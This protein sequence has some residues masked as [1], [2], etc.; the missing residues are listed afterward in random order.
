MRNLLEIEERILRNNAVKAGL[1][2][3]AINRV[4]RA[5]TNAK[6]QKFDKTLEMAKLVKGA[7]DWFVSDEGKSIF[8]EEGLT[9]TKEEF[10]A[11]V[12]GWQ[13]SFAYKVL[14]AGNLEQDVIDTFNSKCD[15]AE[16][17][18]QSVKRNLEALLRFA[19]ATEESQSEGGGDDSEGGEGDG[20]EPQ[21]EVS[22]PTAFTLSFKASMFD[23]SLRNVSVRV[24]V[25]NNA[26]TQNTSEE[27]ELAIAFLRNALGNNQ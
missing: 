14:K 26:K 1:N 6:K 25:E 20:E 11:K 3:T 27:I 17:D 23:E 9:W 10:F 22:I 21:V 13:K 8:E 19:R 15:E 16:N 24:D 4:Q 7:Y 2:L 12:F 5:V 18:G